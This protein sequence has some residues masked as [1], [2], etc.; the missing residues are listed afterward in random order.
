MFPV[1]QPTLMNNLAKAAAGH[2]VPL[3]G[4]NFA[5]LTSYDSDELYFTPNK[6][7]LILPVIKYS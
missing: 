6:K 2:R 7:Y 1:E 5:N 3:K 4:L